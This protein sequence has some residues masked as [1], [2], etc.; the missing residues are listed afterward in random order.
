MHR[1]GHEVLSELLHQHFPHHLDSAKQKIVMSADSERWTAEY[2]A[3]LE[4]CPAAPWPYGL[5]VLDLGWMMSFMFLGI[6]TH[7]PTVSI[8]GF[9]T[10]RTHRKI[11]L[12]I[13]CEHQGHGIHI[14]NCSS[15]T[16]SVT[17]SYRIQFNKQAPPLASSPTTHPENHRWWT[18]QE[19]P[20]AEWTHRTIH[21]QM[22]L[23][24][25]PLN[26]FAACSIPPIR[27]WEGLAPCSMW[28]QGDRGKIL[29]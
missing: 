9:Y 26:C 22:P 19:H 18:D 12:I 6:R 27:G 24:E 25:K 29:E 11:A 21:R 15:A 20:V 10:N 5:G 16:C 4:F 8:T 17:S 7:K 13:M 23:W 1:W 3:S 14:Y 28:I 2:L